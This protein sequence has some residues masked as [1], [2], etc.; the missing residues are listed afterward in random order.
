MQKRKS[1]RQRYR[2]RIDRKRY[3]IYILP[4]AISV[5]L[6]ILVILVI[7]AFIKVSSH[8]SYNTSALASFEVAGTGVSLILDGEVSSLREG[9][10]VDINPGEGIST[11]AHTR[12]FI[13]LGNGDM[14]RIGES[15]T[16]TFQRGEGG[17]IV[18]VLGNGSYWLVA[19]KD[20]SREQSTLLQGK[21]MDLDAYKNVTFG[22]EKN[23]NT[24]T[25]YVVQ[26]ALQAMV[27][28][29]DKIL[30]TVLLR[31]DQEMYL[32]DSVQ[33]YV[34]EDSNIS[35]VSNL[36]PSRKN[37]SWFLWNQVEDRKVDN[38]ES[39]VGDVMSQDKNVT[40]LSPKYE[41]KVKS[42]YV[43]VKGSYDKG[44]AQITV[45]GIVASLLDDGSWSVPKVPL[46]QS[47]KNVLKVE[48]ALDDGTS[49]SLESLV[50]Q[51]QTD[52]PDMPVLISPENNSSVRS[53]KITLMGKVGPEVAR[54][55]INDYVLKKYE[56]GDEQWVYYLSYDYGNMNIGENVYK[57][58]AFDDVGN[59][60]DPLVV[61][62]DYE[63]DET[64]QPS[65]KNENAVSNTN[66]SVATNP[67][68]LDE[69][70][71]NTNAVVSKENSNTNNQS[72]LDKE[73]TTTT[74]SGSTME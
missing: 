45:D 29:G 37:S 23:D 26:G 16:V 10:Q 5:A 67:P 71:V 11:D 57:I 66:A 28:S 4:A 1:R 46:P 35:I 72:T 54:V 50:V 30:K 74:A 60:S 73:D 2:R 7:N 17:R 15:T 44:V 65:L 9:Y 39:P 27:K 42:T 58:Y 31:D 63:P 36:S 51:R 62:L 53:G 43:E 40:V 13:P 25:V 61:T 22:V 12:I 49:Y 64:P 68:V 69:G 20:K 14:L 41:E 52:A 59:K 21:Y 8:Y 19:D 47:G 34:A 24:E 32:D 33:N 48:Y 3:S 6:V 70:N 18:L 38:Y 56:K 55:Q